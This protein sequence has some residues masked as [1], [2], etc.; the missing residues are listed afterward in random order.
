MAGIESFLLALLLIY[1]SQSSFAN[2]FLPEKVSIESNQT[3]PRQNSE[4]YLRWN[5]KKTKSNAIK[6]IM[7]KSV[8]ILGS[9]KVILKVLIDSEGKVETVKPISGKPILIMPSVTASKQWVFRQPTVNRKKARAKG[10]IVFIFT[11]N[12]VTN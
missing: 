4:S 5:A 9:H 8:G 1:Y 10:I 11:Y 7:P 2:L 6:V 12:K 3:N